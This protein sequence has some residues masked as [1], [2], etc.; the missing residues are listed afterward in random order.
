M[1]VL[2]VDIKCD[3]IYDLDYGNVMV[4]IVCF[5]FEDGFIKSIY[6]LILY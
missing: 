6:I 3:F 4:N 2:Y 5:R 1:L